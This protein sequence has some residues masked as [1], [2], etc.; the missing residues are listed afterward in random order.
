M[1]G[2]MIRS[3]ELIMY[4]QYIMT[5]TEVK[6]ARNRLSEMRKIAL[7]S[8]DAGDRGDNLEWYLRA[9]GFEEALKMLGIINNPI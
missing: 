4:K 8:R 5:E 7:M 6:K 9:K 2:A 1:N 3:G